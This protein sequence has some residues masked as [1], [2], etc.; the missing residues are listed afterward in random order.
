M[1]ELLRIARAP[2]VSTHP[3]ATVLEVCK[4]MMNEV[5]GAVVI[6]D[7]DGKLAGIFSER[8]VVGRVV[9]PGLDPAT[10]PVSDVMTRK[11][12][13]ARAGMTMD[14]AVGLMHHGRFRHLPLVKED[15]TVAGM[16]SVRHLLRHRVDQLDLRN[17]DLLAYISADGP[18]G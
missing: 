4:L 15:G 16:I 18:G 17:A 12:A 8:D 14:Q 6:L 10:T 2:A 11:V 3:Q 13:T 9:I 5:V 1:E 7:E